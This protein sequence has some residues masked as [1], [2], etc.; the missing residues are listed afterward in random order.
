MRPFVTLSASYGARG[1][2]IGPALAGRLGVP[3]FD[4]AIPAQVADRLRMSPQDPLLLEER[5]RGFLERLLGTVG[6]ALLLPIAGV[7]TEDLASLVDD[8]TFR[9]EIDDV[10][11]KASDGTAGGVLLGRAGAVVLAGHPRALHVRLDGPVARRVPVIKQVHGLDEDKATKL[12]RDNDGAR[13]AY[14]KQI[15]GADANDPTLYHLVLDSTVIPP[16]VC[17]DLI[18]QAANSRNPP[19]PAIEGDLSAGR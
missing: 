2:E 9:T 10:I 7:P 5:P 4:R 11:R 14:V 12:L 8:S 17:I 19:D 15:Y 6:T 3:F 1:S 13:E 18:A 16:S